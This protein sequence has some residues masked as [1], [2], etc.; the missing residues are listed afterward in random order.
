MSLSRLP[1]SDAHRIVDALLEADE[2]DP[3]IFYHFTP[4]RFTRFRE[5][6]LLHEFADETSAPLF[7]EEYPEDYEMQVR[8]RLGRVL[9]V[10]GR[11][12]PE[13]YVDPDDRARCREWMDKQGI[14]TLIIDSNYTGKDYIVKSTDQIKIVS[15]T[16]PKPPL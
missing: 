10:S 12:K 3:R 9:D 7:R 8:L 2:F 6:N 16:A 15:I 13:G 1:E 5:S 11:S 14:D 4:Y